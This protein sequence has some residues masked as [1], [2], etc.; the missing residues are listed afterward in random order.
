M[1]GGGEVITQFLKADLADE[2]SVFFAPKLFGSGISW[3]RL[4][5][6][7]SVDEAVLLESV[8]I[9]VLGNDVHVRGRLTK[10]D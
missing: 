3:S 5:I 7:T 4:T 9:Q 8:K 1:E 2:L 6:A 10:P